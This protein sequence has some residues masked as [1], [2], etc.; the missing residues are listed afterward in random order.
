MEPDPQWPAIFRA[1]R[2]RIAQ[3]LAPYVLSIEHV[4]STAVPGLLAKA[5]IDIALGLFRLA[6][7][8]RIIPRM[9]KL[10]YVYIPEY[11]DEL[12]ERRFF[13]TPRDRSQPATFNVHAVEVSSAF[14]ERHLAFRDWLRAHPEDRDRYAQLKREAAATHGDELPAYTE[15]KTAFVRAVEEKSL[16]A[17]RELPAKPGGTAGGPTGGKAAGKPGG[18]RGEGA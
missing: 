4:G 5:T 2:R 7:A 8:P 12:P 6:D 1:E 15:A 10:G 16:K 18:A 17:S 14:F 3:A 11:E 9:E 13:R